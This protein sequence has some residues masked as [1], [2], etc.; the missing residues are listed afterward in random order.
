MSLA[1]WHAHKT[2]MQDNSA[3]YMQSRE[4]QETS[5]KLPH[6]TLLEQNAAEHMACDENGSFY[7]YHWISVASLKLAVCPAC[8]SRLIRP[9][10]LATGCCNQWLMS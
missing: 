7:P 4:F 2:C 10:Q 6:R 3:L 8:R 5:Q 1:S 9:P